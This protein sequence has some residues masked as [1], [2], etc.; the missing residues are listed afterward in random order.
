VKEAHHGLIAALDL[1]GFTDVA[2]KGFGRPEVALCFFGFINFLKARL[3]T[4]RAS[5]T[6]SRL[7]PAKSIWIAVQ[8]VAVSLEPIRESCLSSSIEAFSGSGM[9]K[10][11][12]IDQT[13]AQRSAKV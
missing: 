13:M 10:A 9:S 11:R 5:Q 1:I 12:A 4:N 2:M 3:V 8:R 7:A 6:S